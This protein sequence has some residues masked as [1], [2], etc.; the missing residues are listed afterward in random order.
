MTDTTQPGGREAWLWWERRRLRYNL[1][2]AVAGWAAYGA[3]WLTMLGLGEPMPDTPREILSIT[4]FLGTGF[5]AI[6][7]GANLA[8]LAG[9]LTETV[10]R[11]VDVEGFRRRTWS[12]GFWGSIALPFL[13][14][15]FVLSAV[16]AQP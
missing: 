4:L 7:V 5:L 1:G 10:V 15:L 8:Y 12:L 3:V 16:L 13:F 2:L 11:P 9:V 6:M 14:P